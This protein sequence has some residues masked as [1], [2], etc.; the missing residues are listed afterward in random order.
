MISAPPLT[1][2]Q[3]GVIIHD[4]TAIS[5]RGTL[6]SQFNRNPL[7]LSLRWLFHAL[8]TLHDWMLN[9]PRSDIEL[10]TQKFSGGRAGKI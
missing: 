3:A 8:A 10:Y 4:I 6:T 7:V 5:V 1:T 9:Q 2:G